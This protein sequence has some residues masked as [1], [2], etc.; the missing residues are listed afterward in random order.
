MQQTSQAI[1]KSPIEFDQMKQIDN[2]NILPLPRLPSLIICCIA[3]FTIICVMPL[4]STASRRFII[5]L[6]LFIS[7]VGVFIVGGGQQL[8]QQHFIA[9]NMYIIVF[10]FVIFIIIFAFIF[11]CDFRRYYYVTRQCVCRMICG[12]QHYYTKLKERDYDEFVA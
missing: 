7:A 10:I 9:N 11:F 5:A 1:D 12:S 4:P 8:Y 6:I 3:A 2:A